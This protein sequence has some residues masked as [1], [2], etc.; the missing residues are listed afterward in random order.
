MFY[1]DILSVTTHHF[2]TL[3]WNWGSLIQKEYAHFFYRYLQQI[4]SLIN[5]NLWC[6]SLSGSIYLLSGFYI[7]WFSYKWLRTNIV[8]KLNFAVSS[9]WVSLFTI[10]SYFVELLGTNQT[11]CWFCFCI[12]DHLLV[13]TLV[14]S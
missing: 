7:Y 3:H 6:Y 4:H 8:H 14:L 10:C 9:I 1:C 13:L 5:I 2:I 11:F 12:M